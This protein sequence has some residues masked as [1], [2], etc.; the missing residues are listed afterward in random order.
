MNDTGSHLANCDNSANSSPLLNGDSYLA[1]LDDG[2]EV[3]YDGERVQNVT[4]H[5]AFA[6]AARSVAQL[7]D[8]LHARRLATS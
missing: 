3:W 6:N 1:S 4:T 7:Y 5:K 2:R 8:A